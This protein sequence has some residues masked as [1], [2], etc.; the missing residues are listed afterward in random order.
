MFN[1]AVLKSRKNLN[2]KKPWAKKYCF[3]NKNFYFLNKSLTFFKKKLKNFDENEISSPYLY[4][5]F[6]KTTEKLTK[7]QNID[8]FLINNSNT[9]IKKN[10][11]LLTYLKTFNK[12]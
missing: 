4:S 5:K 12:K 9:N 8:F 6:Y 7:L 2:N 3:K 1:I 11:I 10:P